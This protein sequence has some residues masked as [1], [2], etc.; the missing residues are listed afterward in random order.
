M[1]GR[2]DGE[3]A[4]QAGQMGPNCEKRPGKWGHIVRHTPTFFFFVCL[5]SGGTSLLFVAVHPLVFFFFWVNLGSSYTQR[6][7]GHIRC[8]IMVSRH[9][10]PRAVTRR[11]EKS[12]KGTDL[13]R[14]GTKTD[15]DTPTKG[16]GRTYRMSDSG[17]KH[18]KEIL[19]SILFGEHRSWI[20]P[21]REWDG[22]RHQWQ[23]VQLQMAALAQPDTA[24]VLLKPSWDLVKPLRSSPIIGQQGANWVVVVTRVRVNLHQCLDV[25]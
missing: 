9:W 21:M 22:A 16:R 23:P 3:T 14:L 7:W 25:A 8:G 13:G 18:G 24:E 6:F 11:E 1:R 17:A 5:G 12:G 15:Q 2:N 10:K 20:R 4:I 19:S